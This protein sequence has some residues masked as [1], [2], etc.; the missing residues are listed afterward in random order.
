MRYEDAG[1]GVFVSHVGKQWSVVNC[2]SFVCIQDRQCAYALSF[3][4]D[5]VQAQNE[6]GFTVMTE[7]LVY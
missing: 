2:S 5:F 4:H 7:D 3:D 1:L 6:F